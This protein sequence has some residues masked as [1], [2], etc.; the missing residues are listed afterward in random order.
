MGSGATWLAL[1]ALA[2]GVV[3]GPETLR[4]RLEV[5][6]SPIMDPEGWG[7]YDPPAVEVTNGELEVVIHDAD[8]AGACSDVEVRGIA[9]G[10]L[11]VSDDG[12][13][14]L[15]GTEVVIE[16][17]RSRPLSLDRLTEGPAAIEDW[18]TRPFGSR[19]EHRLRMAWL[20]EERA[21]CQL[22]L[23]PCAVGDRG[24]VL[25]C[26]PEWCVTYAPGEP[27]PAPERRACPGT[28]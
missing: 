3:E 5:S 8:G 22:R 9:L 2:D 1:R 16:T 24:P 7:S 6:S 21:G 25:V 11:E 17:D 4:L 20:P 10:P 23:Q 26:S 27:V 19:V 13:R 15:R 14:G 12:C 28:D 18:Q